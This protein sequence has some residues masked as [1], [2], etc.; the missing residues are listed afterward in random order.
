LLGINRGS[1]YRGPPAREPPPTDRAGALAGP[2]PSRPERPPGTP[3]A[4]LPAPPQDPSWVAGDAPQLTTA[5]DDH[6]LLQA[7]EGVIETFPGYGYRRVAKELQ[8][9][10]WRV[11]HKRV[12]RVMGAAGL[13]HRRKRRFVRTTDSN[14]CLPIFPNLLADCG[15]RRLTAPDQAW[16]ADLTYVRLGEGFCY[17][18][19]ILDAF[20]RRVLGWNL[21]PNLNV[22][23][24]LAALEQA[25][26]TRKPPPGWIHHSDRGVQYACHA[27]V[28]RLRAAGAQI[29]MT[30]VGAPRENAQAERFMRTIKEEE[31]DLQDYANIDAARRSIGGFIENIYNRKRLHSGLGYLPPSEF[32]EP[33]LTHETPD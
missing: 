31:V 2:P 26:H 14:H 13:L 22:R 32:E 3:E 12:H 24:S 7:I 28:A 25:L 18:A 9:D 10:G 1:Y 33:F 8:R 6:Q 21:S 17:L 5:S 11:N 19:V 29:S 16:A 23:L 15:W 27:Y 4:G 30:A 20:S